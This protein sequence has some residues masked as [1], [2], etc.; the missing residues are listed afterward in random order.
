MDQRILWIT[1]GFLSF[2]AFV[3]P[4]RVVAFLTTLVSI[5]LPRRSK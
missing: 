2:L 1:I 5:R 3:G 4:L